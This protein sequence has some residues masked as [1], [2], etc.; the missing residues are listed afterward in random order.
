MEIDSEKLISHEMLTNILA[1]N[2]ET[3]I[4]TWR[5]NCGTRAKSGSIAGTITPVGY[6]AI[7]INGVI[8]REH[9]LAWF[10][11]NGVW[12][13]VIDHKNRIKNDNRIENLRS[14]THVDNGKNV[15]IKKSN[16]SGF[17]GVYWSSRESKWIARAKINGKDTFLGYF[18]SIEI[19]AKTYNEYAKSK[20]GEFYAGEESLRNI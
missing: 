1:Y 20:N 7:R 18:D 17:T 14:V 2:K 5:I 8:Y 16:T 12:P 11:V 9:R 10:Y 3:G 19:A 6:R 15:A 13:I 4:F